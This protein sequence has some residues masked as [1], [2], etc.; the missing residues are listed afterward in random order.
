MKII[1]GAVVCFIFVTV[2]FSAPVAEDGREETRTVKTENIQVDHQHDGR[3]D[4]SFYAVSPCAAASSNMPVAYAPDMMRQSN[5][6][7]LQARYFNSELYGSP[8][9]MRGW[10]R[11]EEPYQDSQEVL[12]YSDGN[13]VDT[14][15]MGNMFRSA[16]LS[17]APFKSARHYNGQVASRFGGAYGVFPNANVGDCSVPLLFSCSPSIV[18][19]QMMNPDSQGDFDSAS[20]VSGKPSYGYHGAHS[21]YLQGLPSHIDQATNEHASVSSLVN[22]AQN[23]KVLQ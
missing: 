3:L 4:R 1:F 5:F 16:P 22:H 19:G 7:P 12:R 14:A 23:S 10:Y 20:P 21:H 18:T 11:T 2:V 8:D 13:F 17:F 6:G 15:Q 9:Y